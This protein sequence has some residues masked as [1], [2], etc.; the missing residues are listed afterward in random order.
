MTWLLVA[1]VCIVTEPGTVKCDTQAMRPVVGRYE[2]FEVVK[3]FHAFLE[4]QT[5]WLKP[6]YLFVGC[7]LGQLS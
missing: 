1:T 4:A 5:A 7:K 2:C 3:P 6:V